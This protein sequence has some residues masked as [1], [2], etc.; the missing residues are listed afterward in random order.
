MPK[1]TRSRSSSDVYVID[2]TVQRSWHRRAKIAMIVAWIVGGILIA[3][4]LS[5]YTNP[6][7]ALLAGGL[8]GSMP[9]AVAYVAVLTWPVVRVTLWWSDVI[10]ASIIVLAI[11]IGLHQVLPG[12]VVVMVLVGIAGVLVG[13]PKIRH[14]TVAIYWCAVSRHRLRASFADFIRV[15]RDGSLPFILD[16][17]PTPVGERVRVWLRPG[18]SLDYLRDRGDQLAVAC[19][20]K[21]VA[22]SAASTKNAALV[23]FDIK[24]RDTLSAPVDSVLEVPDA[25]ARDSSSDPADI[26]ALDLTD[27]PEESVTAQSTPDTKSA[28]KPAVSTY[29]PTAKKTTA[30]ATVVM[31]E[32]GEDVSDWI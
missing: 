32:S 21:S 30:Q 19:L 29:T 7:L 31:S 8:L 14:T 17:R 11:T 26:T 2:T 3:L 20:A 5:V 15:N 12:P 25:P 22:V 23:W 4:A 16:A 9:A 28:A 10:T 27:V 1:S 24:R 18:L 6:V 13:P